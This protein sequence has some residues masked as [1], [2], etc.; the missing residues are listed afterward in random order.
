MRAVG[1]PKK[2]GESPCGNRPSRKTTKAIR[3]IN[4][5]F[6]RHVIGLSNLY[7]TVTIYCLDF[8]LKAKM[9]DRGPLSLKIR[10]HSVDCPWRKMA[11]SIF[12]LVGKDRH[13]YSCDFKRKKTAYDYVTRSVK[14]RILCVQ[15]LIPFGQCL[16]NF[17]RLYH[18]SLQTSNGWYISWT[19]P[20]WAF[21]AKNGVNRVQFQNDGLMTL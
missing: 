10:N 16:K 7:K 20:R 21:R 12:L 1:G 3:V 5:P 11:G 6:E 8:W 18:G 14:I 4:T 17:D 19:G 9:C 15:L 2:G 13:W